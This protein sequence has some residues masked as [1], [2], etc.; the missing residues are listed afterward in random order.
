MDT[1]TIERVRHKNGTVHERELRRKGHR[2]RVIILTL[3]APMIL[4]YV[5]SGGYLT[6][7]DVETYTSPE[8][9]GGALV[10]QTRNSVY[11]PRKEVPANREG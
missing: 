11:T 5:D 10:V 1:Y 3:G 7:T 9:I 6:T 2:V 4:E 8:Y